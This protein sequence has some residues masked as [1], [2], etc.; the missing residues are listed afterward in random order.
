MSA[1]ARPE[2]FAAQVGKLGFEIAGKL[3]FPDHHPYP[4]PSLA[5]IAAAYRKSDAAAVLMT[6]KDRVKLSGRLDL[7]AWDRAVS[8]PGVALASPVDA[9][10]SRSST[11]A[12]SS[13]VWR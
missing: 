13:T 10:S 4:T 3:A 6:S 7:P 9:P 2:G 1:V 8:A 5:R 12:T 11:V